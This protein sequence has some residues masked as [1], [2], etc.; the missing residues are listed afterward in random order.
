MLTYIPFGPLV[1][2]SQRFKKIFG[3]PIFSLHEYMMTSL[4][5]R[6]MCIH[7]RTTFNI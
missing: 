2:C 3:F 1:N 6:V 5:K 4:Q 7:Y